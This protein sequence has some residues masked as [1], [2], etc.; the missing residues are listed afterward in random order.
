MGLAVM[1]LA[2]LCLAQGWAVRQVGALAAVMAMLG[3][4]SSTGHIMYAHMKELM[5]A[6]M[7]GMA[8][9]GVNLFTM[10]GPAVLLHALGWIVDRRSGISPSGAGAYEAAFFAAFLGVLLALAL[11]LFA[12]ERKPRDT[13]PF[14]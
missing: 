11:Y 12:R 6:H 14:S 4:A 9:T 5:P 8:L 13:P 1:A 7:T 3:L 10:L 2:E